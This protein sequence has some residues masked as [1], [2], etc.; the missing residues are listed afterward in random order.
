MLDIRD[1]G[2]DA[3][4]LQDSSQAIQNAIN[5]AAMAVNSS[6]GLTQGLDGVVY[7][8]A[9]TF[10]I[11]QQITI[12][13]LSGS[14]PLRL[15]G[16]AAGNSTL[17][18]VWPA[19]PTNFSDAITPLP[20]SVAY[21]PVLTPTSPGSLPST[22]YTLTYTYFN[23]TTAVESGASPAT[24]VAVTNGA[25][26]YNLNANPPTGYNVVRFYLSYPDLNNPPNVITGF[27]TQSTMLTPL[28][29]SVSSLTS[30]VAG[31]LPPTNALLTQTSLSADNVGQFV[32]SLGILSG[33]VITSFFRKT[34]GNWYVVGL[35]APPI[36]AYS[37][38]IGLTTLYSPKMIALGTGTLIMEN[39]A[40][41]NAG[42]DGAPFIFSG[43]CVLKLSNLQFEGP[44]YYAPSPYNRRQ[45]TGASTNG[46]SLTASTATFTTSDV[47]AAV[48]GQGF[49]P[50]TYIEAYGTSTSCTL[51]Q[52]VGVQSGLAP[53]LIS[54]Y[55]DAIVLGGFG[56]VQDGTLGGAFAGYGTVIERCSFD[57]IRRALFCRSSA[58]AVVFRDNTLTS[59]CN[60]GFTGEA[61]VD[62]E[63]GVTGCDSNVVSGNIIQMDYRTNGIRFLGAAH[64][65]AF[66]NYLGDAGNLKDQSGTNTVSTSYALTPS[67][68]ANLI[69][70]GEFSGPAISDPAN[71]NTVLVPYSQ[72]G[73]YKQSAIFSQPT[74]FNASLTANAVSASLLALQAP[75]VGWTV[76][77]PT[78]ST[79]YQYQVYPI[80]ADGLTGPGTI[81]N[82]TNIP[83]G[84]LG[85]MSYVQLAIT[86]VPGAIYYYVFGRTTGNMYQLATVF[87][88]D[89]VTTTWVDNNVPYLQPLRSPPNAGLLGPQ[90]VIQAWSGQS[91]NVQEWQNS[92]GTALASVDAAGYA[93][94]SGTAHLSSD[95][96]IA[97]TTLTNVSGFS[98]PISVSQTWSFEAS[99]EAVSAG[100]N[101][102]VFAVSVPTGAAVLLMVEG[103]SSSGTYQQSV[104]T[105]GAP[106][107]S[108]AFVTFG[109]T[110]PGIVTL[111][112]TV[113]SDST[114]SGT[115]QLQAASGAVANFTLKKGSYFAA[116]KSA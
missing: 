88:N 62:L 77:G 76:F 42:S 5:A 105:A 81:V 57:R 103:V 25:F 26:N 48:I 22:T 87:P 18:F 21:T 41:T 20:L 67:A 35:S 83:T 28:I 96:V 71:A 39:V 107:A 84:G 31:N 34:E 23:T 47:G 73:Q 112:G 113:T 93:F 106:T 109:P 59:N 115:V 33:A 15:L 2:A 89:P 69:S 64:S 50:N 16:S 97:N 30:L 101:G 3:T 40:L 100:S 54:S 29:G 111:R 10:K 11:Q 58:N 78:G 53:W 91:K 74:I 63:G 80:N 45:L 7:I 36:K 108:A 66:A 72:L 12:P 70:G 85:G 49:P 79:T 92:A 94:F 68:R 55:Q 102:G 6:A 27:L 90:F 32:R 110:P 99:F 56:S 86:N 65:V 1:F 46:T 52:S 43:R 116:R 95:L 82:I 13:T 114:H 17:T 75:P 104:V 14:K 8:P 38:G 19:A 61:A 37:V 4:G 24:S 98:F 44:Q 60:C 51:S 9:G